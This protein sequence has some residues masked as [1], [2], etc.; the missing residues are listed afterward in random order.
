MENNLYPI[1]TLPNQSSYPLIHDV[2]IHPFKVNHDPRGTLTEALKT[3]WDDVYNT[4]HRP[5]TQMYF[6]QTEAG[7]ARDTNEWHVHPTGQ[8]DRFFVIQGTIVT[9]I[10]DAREDSPT[11]SKLNLFLMGE[12][13]DDVGQYLLV[14][15]QRT[16]HGYVVVSSQPAILGNFPTRLYDPREEGRTPMKDAL[17]PDG[18]IFSWDQVKTLVQST[19]VPSP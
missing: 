5:F 2:V 18:S 15:P 7:V 4:N 11:K 13:A 16:Y 10:Y 6:S 12:T 14:I 19:L 1:F 9:A 17:L 8:E 3:T